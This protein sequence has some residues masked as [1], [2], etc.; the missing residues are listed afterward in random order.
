MMLGILGAKLLRRD[1]RAGELRALFAAIFIATLCLGSISL[2]SDRV[3]RAIKNQASELLGGD[4][5]VS[6]NVPIPNSWLEEAKNKNLRTAETTRFLSM[7]SYKKQFALSAIKSVDKNYPLRGKLKVSDESFKSG[8]EVSSIPEQGTVWLQARLMSQLKIKLG[9]NITI[10]NTNLKVTKILQFEPDR[11]GQWLLIAPRVLINEKDLPK[12]NIIQ[13]GSRVTYDLLLVGENNSIKAYANWL[14][15]QLKQGQSMADVNDERRGLRDTLNRVFG[16]LNI[17]AFISIILAGVAIAMAMHRYSERHSKT[18][19]LFRCFGSRESD[20]LK[21]FISNMLMISTIGIFLGALFGFL[22]QTYLENLLGPFLPAQL[23]KTSLWEMKYSVIIGYLIVLGFGLPPLLKLKKTSPATVLRKESVKRLNISVNVY[24]FLFAFLF[25]VFLWQ[26]QDL[27]LSIFLLGVFLA[28]SMLLFILGSFFIDA[29]SKIPSQSIRF[30]LSNIIK[31]KNESLIHIV[32]FGLTLLVVTLLILLR[33]NLLYYWQEELP[34]KTPNYFIIN[35]L[36]DQV[37]GFKNILENNNIGSENLYPLVRGRIIELN[38]QP[39]MQVLSEDAKDHNALH[40]ALNLT[41]TDKLP[42]LNQVVNG[43]WWN[44]HTKEPVISVEEKM[45]EKLNLRLGDVLGFK[46]GADVIQAKI[47]NTRSLSWA[48]FTPNFFV[49]FSPGS[50]KGYP[51]TYMTSFYLPSSKKMFL[52]T[53]IESYSNITIIDVDDII[54][55]IR[56]IVDKGNMAVSF[57]V[58]FMFLIGCIVLYASIQMTIKSREHETA[59][60]RAIGATKKIVLKNLLIEF[61]SLGLIAGLIAAL[62][63][64]IVTWLLTQRIFYIP[65]EFQWWPFLIVPLFGASLVSLTGL[66]AS[67]PILKT[68][69]LRLLR[70][71]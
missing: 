20:I 11:S 62:T 37:K 46:I 58:L 57:I 25:S 35:I 26:T 14:K 29:V 63:G 41:W 17:A 71:F 10:G 70:T 18:A 67:L 1:W 31:R 47:V 27:R 60:F 30:G 6:S 43:E 33:Y 38:G 54:F 59:I 24:M 50:L 13:P 22:L 12:T 32:A 3:Q 66:F 8:V 61:F 65:Y 44:N 7:I 69:P 48:S 39:I 9:D 36:P 68:T 19:A 40:R 52:N 16:Y 49:I 53:L 15:P 34:E 5:V 55:R 4:V 45:A 21:I 56:N 64:T 28:V 42:T 2:F 23:P 51:T